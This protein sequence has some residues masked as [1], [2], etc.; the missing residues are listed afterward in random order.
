MNAAKGTPKWRRFR[1]TIWCGLIAVALTTLTAGLALLGPRDSEHTPPIV[2]P[3]IR[4]AQP[5][6][7]LVGHLGAS[8][9][10][11]QLFRPVSITIWLSLTLVINFACG[12]ILGSAFDIASTLIPRLNPTNHDA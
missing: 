9:S 7:F 11:D 10:I 2:E 1:F 8:S 6:S 12:A 4:M 3:W 5:T